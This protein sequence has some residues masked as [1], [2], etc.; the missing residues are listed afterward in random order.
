[1]KHL[2]QLLVLAL[3]AIFLT[4]FTFSSSSYAQHGAHGAGFVDLNGDGYHDNAP[5]SDGDG[6]NDRMQDADGDGIP[7]GTDPDWVKP[8]DGTG[9]KHGQMKSGRSGKMLL[10][11]KDF[12]FKGAKSSQ[13]TG[14]GICDGT[15]PKG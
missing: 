5:A 9:K 6:I 1:M 10:L 2:T 15:G 12:G 8:Q 4:L 3:A 7:N 14:T 11:H 13:R